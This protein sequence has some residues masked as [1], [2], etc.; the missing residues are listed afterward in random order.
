MEESPEKR[1]EINACARRFVPAPGRSFS[2]SRKLKYV[3]LMQRLFRRNIQ[4]LVRFRG[5]NLGGTMS[6]VDIWEVRLL[7]SCFCLR[8]TV[9]LL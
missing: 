9:I 4:C 1:V 2:S 3:E 5:E 7:E 6:S 8:V